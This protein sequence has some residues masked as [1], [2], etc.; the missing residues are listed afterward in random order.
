MSQEFV[1]SSSLE[2]EL[3]KIQALSR[4]IGEIVSKYAGNECESSEPVLED[5][6]IMANMIFELC[7]SILEEGSHP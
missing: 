4:S 2:E 6:Q 3:G 7:R 1:M 5:A